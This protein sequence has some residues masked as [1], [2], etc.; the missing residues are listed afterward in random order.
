MN[1]LQV[2]TAA[3]STVKEFDLD[4]AKSILESAIPYAFDHPD[5]LGGLKSIS[6][7]KERGEVMLSF[8]EPLVQA[9]YLS[10]QW[11]VYQ[12]FI[13]RIGL[14][15]DACIYAFKT[16]VFGTILR[17]LNEAKKTSDSVDPLVFL[18]MGMCEKIL[19]NYEDAIRC[20]E[21]AAAHLHDNPEV[22]CH[23][24]DGYAL[25]EE[26]DRAKVLFREAF[27][28]D[29]QKIELTFLESE[30]I[31][32]LIAH[33]SQRFKDRNAVKEWIPVYGTILGIFSV[34]RELRAVEYGRLRQSI[35]SLECE[36]ANQPNRRAMLE[37]RLLNR[38][39]WQIDHLVNQKEPQEKIADV[40][41]KIK[42]VNPEIHTLYTK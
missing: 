35:Y 40:L 23:L 8:A 26:T 18:H 37:P 36:L 15:S 3:W 28:H 11:L 25:L 19:G 38:Y 29:P 41:I 9:E 32:R 39:F 2:V 27:F 34:K 31:H 22:L 1:I 13:H 5:L 16:Y 30:M 12:D 20:C 24:A 10:S 42:S 33:V 21:K 14:N 7:W 17:L 6:F 4:K